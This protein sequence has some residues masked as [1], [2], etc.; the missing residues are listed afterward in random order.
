MGRLYNAQTKYLQKQCIVHPRESSLR[1]VY[2]IV[3]IANS[4]RQ[5]DRTIVHVGVLH[6]PPLFQRPWI[7]ASSEVQGCVRCN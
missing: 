4:V 1:E 5:S 6:Q 2:P 3:S 7:E